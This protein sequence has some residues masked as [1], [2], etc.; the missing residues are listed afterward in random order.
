MTKVHV[1]KGGILVLQLD[2]VKE[3][4]KRCPM[5]YDDIIEC[6]AFVNWSRIERGQDAVLALSFYA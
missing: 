3:F 1:P 6:S 5:I 4:A 2:H